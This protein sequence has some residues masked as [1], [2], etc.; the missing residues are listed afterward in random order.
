MVVLFSFSSHSQ[1]QVTSIMAALAHLSQGLTLVLFTSWTITA[2][3]F[4]ALDVLNKE[5][6]LIELIASTTLLTF[7]ACRLLVATQSSSTTT[8]TTTNTTLA[9]LLTTAYTRSR[10]SALAFLLITISWLYGI[11]YKFILLFFA[12][13]FGS[14][15]AAAI[16]NGA[17]VETTSE[18][19]GVDTRFGASTAVSADLAELR[20]DTGL[21]ADLPRIIKGVP[22]RLLVLLVVLVWVDFVTLAL[23]VLRLAWRAFGGLLGERVSTPSLAAADSDEGGEGG[24]GKVV[25]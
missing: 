24:N 22:P 5:R 4:T 6:D 18:D 20:Q 11:V 7:L 9:H 21:A 14:A 19:M 15:L 10:T 23:Y 13:L 8:T 25:G 17:L 12:T 2:L 1:L 3:G 16:Y